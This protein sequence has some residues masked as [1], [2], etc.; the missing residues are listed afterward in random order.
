MIAQAQK[1]TAFWCTVCGKKFTRKEHLERH[2]PHHTGLKPFGCNE[3]KVFFGRQDLLRRH[4]SL[5]HLIA[6]GSGPIP[7]R[8]GLQKDIACENCFKAKCQCDKQKPCCGACEKKGIKC[9]ERISKRVVKQGAR[10]RRPTGPQ[11]S[12]PPAQPPLPELSCTRAL[13]APDARNQAELVMGTS[14]EEGMIDADAYLQEKT[15]S[16]PPGDPFFNDLGFFNPQYD[17]FMNYNQQNEPFDPKNVAF[18][19]QDDLF[20]DMDGLSP[21]SSVDISMDSISLD[22]FDGIVDMTGFG[23]YSGFTTMDNTHESLAGHQEVFNHF[24]RHNRSA[25]AQH[26]NQTLPQTLPNTPNAFLQGLRAI[27]QP[28]QNS[29]S[30]LRSSSQHQNAFQGLGQIN[31]DVVTFSPVISQQAFPHLEH[32]TDNMAIL[33]PTPH[34]D[35]SFVT[36]HGLPSPVNTTPS[37][38]PSSLRAQQEGDKMTASR[39]EILNKLKS[40]YNEAFANRPDVSFEDFIGLYVAHQAKTGNGAF[41]QRRSV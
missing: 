23:G 25:S 16:P 13:S 22:N 24:G 31:D 27:R 41:S 6:N 14:M 12:A 1:P 9:V 7:T 28:M 8:P 21:S 33:S 40:T 3:C 32:T 20:S 17:H 5:Y 4:E 26:N 36:A 11:V 34:Q 18:S 30:G 37:P 29:G 2:I 10:A 19:S 39:A 35:I 15:A 38:P